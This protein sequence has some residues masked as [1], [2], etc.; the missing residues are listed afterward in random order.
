MKWLFFISLCLSSLT[1]LHAQVL[2]YSEREVQQ[3][4]AF[5]E[6]E[7]WF[8]LGQWEKAEKKLKALVAEH[9]NLDA[10]HY[11]LARLYDTLGQYQQALTH[12]VQAVTLAPDN[13]WYRLEQAH[14]LEALRRFD[15]AAAVFAALRRKEPHVIEW[16]FREASCYIEAG[17]LTKAVKVYEALE[18][19]IGINEELSRRKH[20]LYLAMNELK[21]A[22]RTL[23]ELIDAFP[24]KPRYRYLLAQFYEHNGQAE[25]AYK[26]WRQVAER[27][28]DDAQA[29]LALVQYDQ[30]HNSEL[31]RLQQ[32]KEVFAKPDLPIDAKLKQIVPFIQQLSQNPQA[33][34]A[35]LLLELTTLLTQVHPTDAKAWAAAADVYYCLDQ[36]EKAIELYN[37]ALEADEATYSVWEQ[38]LQIL[39]QGARYEELL[40]RSE[41]ALEVFPNQPTIWYFNALGWLETAQPDQALASVE[42]AS[43]MPMDEPLQARFEVLRARISLQQGKMD[44]AKELLDRALTQ[45]PQ[46]PEAWEALGDWYAAQG[47][48]EQ[49]RQLWRKAASAG[50]TANSLLRKLQQ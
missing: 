42:N 16:Y 43:F 27:W 31:Q 3:Q 39:W 37:R 25:R 18:K 49:A 2:Q 33:P 9:P 46:L 47:N 32:L 36:E 22:E 50:G 24:D 4:A 10:A 6:G 40:R 28:P 45:W 12:I 34:F 30:A 19:K 17:Q 5:L 48:M 41:E 38:L 35:Q 29:K 7:K 26:V 1:V 44:R 11:T 15:Q 23:Q 20:A 14:L 21:K 13:P 8:L